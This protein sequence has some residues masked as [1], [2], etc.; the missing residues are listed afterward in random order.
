MAGKLFQVLAI[1]G[2]RCTDMNRLKRNQLQML[3]ECICAISYPLSPVHMEDKK[4]SVNKGIKSPLVL[5][6]FIP[7]TKAQL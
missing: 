6:P 4:W 7:A 5:S 3:H 1:C 2:N